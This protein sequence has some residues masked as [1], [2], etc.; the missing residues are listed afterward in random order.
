MQAHDQDELRKQAQ[1]V[2]TRKIGTDSNGR[3]QQPAEPER[4]REF[5]PPSVRTREFRQ[6]SQQQAPE[7]Q[8]EFQEAPERPREFQ[9]GSERD[10]AENTTDRPVAETASD[11]AP[12][13]RIERHPV[14]SSG[15][16]PQVA[17]S[18]YDIR[19]PRHSEIYDLLHSRA[20][21]R[22][23]LIVNEVLGRPKALRQSS[24]PE[25]FGGM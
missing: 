5:R 3:D 21:L 10:L 24:D 17:R 14:A 18:A 15:G 1:R 6:P 25:N 4:P 12:M 20:S 22:R 11:R 19:A 9:Q 13:T 23:A 2:L 8:R 16:A 7:R